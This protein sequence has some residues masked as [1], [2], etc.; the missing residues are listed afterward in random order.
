MAEGE[1]VTVEAASS[2]PSAALEDG[3]Q[4]DQGAV[5]PSP[6]SFDDGLPS[7]EN[8]SRPPPTY[9]AS[10]CV[11]HV[12]EEVTDGR[13]WS[14]ELSSKCTAAELFAVAQDGLD[15]MQR[16]FTPTKRSG[17]EPLNLKTS[18]F[19]YKPNLAG[20]GSYVGSKDGH[21]APTEESEPLGE[22]GASWK[23]EQVFKQEEARSA[24]AQGSYSETKTWTHVT[25]VELIECSAP[26]MTVK[27]N[28]ILARKYKNTECSVGRPRETFC[29]SFEVQL[30]AKDSETE[31]GHCIVKLQGTCAPL[32]D[33][34]RMLGKKREAVAWGVAC[35]AGILCLPCG[36]TRLCSIH[37]DN[38][39][40]SEA[41]QEEDARKLAR[42]FANLVANA[43]RQVPKKT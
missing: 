30:T 41:A 1:Q 24:G 8:A 40:N 17:I 13:Q 10:E 22:V 28:V 26:T 18:A 33:Y 25:F 3:L 9:V 16:F 2:P 34:K 36:I 19:I 39:G 11:V 31:E 4:G 32:K 35:M 43:P 14:T 21:W 42:V 23:C 7:Y 38:L 12:E 15:W 27:Y 6:P 37:P 20:P 29:K 5:N